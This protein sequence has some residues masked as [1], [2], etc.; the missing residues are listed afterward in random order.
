MKKGLGAKSLS[1]SLSDI[2][3]LPT[4]KKS[5]SL[6]D[7]QQVTRGEGKKDF[8]SLAQQHTS[9]NFFSNFPF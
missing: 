8:F 9:T 4:T 3:A 5:D 7:I 1:V 2:S 6:P